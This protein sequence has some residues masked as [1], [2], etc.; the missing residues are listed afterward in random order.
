MRQVS[1]IRKL[2]F[3]CAVVGVIALLSATLVQRPNVTAATG[4]VAPE[5]THNATELWLNGPPLT[6]AELRGKVLLVDFWTFDCWNCYRSFPWLKALEAEFDDEDF[7]VVGVHAPEFE[8]ERDI[9]S[10]QDKADE[11]GL[12]H[13]IMID[14][15][16]PY[17]KA[18]G[19]RFWPSFYLIDKHGLV[20]HAFIGETH[21]G[22]KQARAIHDAVV[23]LLAEPR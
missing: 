13:P 5:F 23:A 4:V 17:W 15:D 7:I 3:L 14:N 18:M 20:R 10:V 19:N 22:D 11:F 16:F 1:I 21:R 6:L 8:H 2:S 12:R 9:A